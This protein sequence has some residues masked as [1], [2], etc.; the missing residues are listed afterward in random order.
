M[1]N[2]TIDNVIKRYGAT[3]VMHGVSVGIEDGEFVVL[4]GPSG[5]GKSTLLRMLAGL[6]EISEGTISIGDKVVNDVLPKERD[7]AMVFQSYALYPHKTVFDNI[8]FPLKMAKRSKQEIAEKV[9]QAAEILDLSK[10]LKRYPKEL[11]G[12]QRQRVAMGRAIVRDPQVFLFDEPLSNLDAKLRVTMRVEIKELHQRLG[13]TIVYVTHD[14]IEAMTMADKIVV[15]RDG[16]VEQVGSPLDLYDRPDNVFVAGFIGSPSMNFIQGKVSG[17]KF[18]SNTG[19]L[20]DLPAAE[21]SEGQE[22]IYG[23]RPEDITI[24]ETG[25]PLEVIVVEPTGS[26]TQVFAKHGT[27]KIDAL[28]K[29]RISARPTSKLGFIFDPAK[30][31]LFDHATERRI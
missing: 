30:A 20:L 26:E 7:I 9:T 12:G 29:E 18:R 15:M 4:V 8:G 10:Y 23:I 31:H 11:S 19:L 24:G 21:T 13:T 16:R 22:I 1:A 6:E 3:Q 25:V 14:Q 27:A 2:V 5:C 17:G 28:V